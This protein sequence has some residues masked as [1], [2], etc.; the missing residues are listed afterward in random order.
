M[1]KKLIQTINILI[2]NQPTNLTIRPYRRSK[3]KIK[4][5]K[6]LER[7]VSNALDFK[8][9]NTQYD[10][11]VVIWTQARRHLNKR[12]LQHILV[13][14]GSV[15]IESLD[16][17]TL[18]IVWTYCYQVNKK[19]KPFEDPFAGQQF[20]AVLGRWCTKRRYY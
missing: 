4:D 17:I 13:V 15:K 20:D 16:Q 11:F 12:D 14:K 1:S 3:I 18:D 2:N 10:E 7:L 5:I 8:H 6:E 19:N 9:Y